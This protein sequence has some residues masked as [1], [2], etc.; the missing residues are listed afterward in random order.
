[1]KPKK[2]TKIKKQRGKK[3]S[4]RGN[5]DNSENKKRM[6]KKKE[7]RKYLVIGIPREIRYN[8]APIK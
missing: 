6:L 2:E 8:I 5:R 4:P 7:E 3:N 1:M